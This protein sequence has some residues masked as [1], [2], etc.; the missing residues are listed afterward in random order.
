MP[1]KSEYQT[2]EA[3]PFQVFFLGV[4]I[5]VIPLYDRNGVQYNQNGSHLNEITVV[6]CPTKTPEFGP[7]A[8]VR[9][10]PGWP[11]TSSGVRR[12]GS[13]VW[14]VAVLVFFGGAI[15]SNHVITSGETKTH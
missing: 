6:H 2:G 10:S 13:V 12:K 8:G 7:N 4:Y 11:V 5:I 15:G 3:I 1:M 9:D 14:Q